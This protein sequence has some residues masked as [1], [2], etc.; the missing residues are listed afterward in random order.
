MPISQVISAACAAIG[1]AAFLSARAAA[2]A[3]PLE[4]AIA[5]ALATDE[6]HDVI[7]GGFPDGLTQR[8]AE[9][10]CSIA[11]GKSN[12]EIAHELGLSVRTVERHITNL[13]AKI[14]ARGKSDATAYAFRH[15]LIAQ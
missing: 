11:S 3:L 5:E 4:V 13:Y 1:D 15:K 8:E 9:I 14:D 10:L 7:T 12:R 6:T 2:S